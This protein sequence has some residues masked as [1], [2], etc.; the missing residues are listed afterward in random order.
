MNVRRLWVNISFVYMSIWLLV[1]MCLMLVY[2]KVILSES[3]MP[4]LVA[5]VVA[6]AVCVILGLVSLVIDSKDESIAKK[7]DQR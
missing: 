6:V 4:L 2:G 7:V 5:E 1:N 3:L